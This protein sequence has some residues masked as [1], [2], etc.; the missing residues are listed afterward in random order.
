MSVSSHL[1]KLILTTKNFIWSVYIIKTEN[2]IAIAWGW[3]CVS[4][5]LNIHIIY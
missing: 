3:H 2:T 1:E 5:A 4:I